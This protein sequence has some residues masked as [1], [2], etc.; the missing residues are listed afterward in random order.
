MT[1]EREI[2]KGLQALVSEWV[3][4]DNSDKNREA[5]VNKIVAFIEKHRVIDVHV[6]AGESIDSVTIDY[7]V[8]YKPQAE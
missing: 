8:S 7:S 4:V 6:Y 1:V 2:E 5:I 3:G